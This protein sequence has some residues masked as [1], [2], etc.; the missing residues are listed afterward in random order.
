MRPFF[1]FSR[2]AAN[3]VVPVLLTLL[4]KQDE[5][6]GD[7]EYNIS[8]AAYQCLQLYAQAVGAT[9]IPPVIQF[10]E[11][12]LR[13]ED[14]HNRDAAVSAFGAIMDGPEEKVLE[15]IVKSGMQPLISMM[16]DPSV[17]VRDSTAYALGRITEACSEA[18]D[19]AQ[20]LEPLLRSLFTGLL[21]SPKMGASC[22]WAL[23]NLAERFAGEYGAQQ[24]PITPHF[25]EAVSNLLTVTARPDCET[26]VRTAA[27]E[28]L[29]AFV[30]SAAIESLPAIASLSDVIIKRLEETIPMQTQVVSVEDKITLED[31]QTSLCAVLQA[32]IQRLDK[33]IMPQ[34][35]RIMQ[36]QLQIL[37]TV[38]GKSL[39]P[40]AV[41]ATIGSLA[42]TMEEE[43][44]K[45]MEAFAPFLYNALGNQEEPSLCSMAI[46]L[47]SD[48]TRST[49]ERSQPFCDN[50]MNYLL[51]NL[52]VRPR[53]P[54][55]YDNISAFRCCSLLTL[56][57]RALRFPTSSSLQFSSA[58]EILPAPSLVTSRRTCRLSLGS[59]SK[60]RLSLPHPKA[61][62][63][64]SITSYPYGRV[65]WTLGVA[66][67]VP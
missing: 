57:F 38:G 60:R 31:I 25:N 45:Y 55:S 33:E 17:Q 56:Y 42:N 49:G 67:L 6:A 12:N 32:I 50:F 1:N 44:I 4:T 39:V 51:N 28:V 66:L 37:Q 29:N 21:N 63:R 7:D 59:C 24:N 36:V 16:D 64:C 13:S 30:Q 52:R 53:L 40:E 2:V 14:W 8:R 62:M 15:P 11:A 20:H 3:E 61:P 35:D 19:A 22:C 47:V 43:F 65:S 46:G 9:V 23:M 48:I 58:S 54:S 41:F 26:A 34:G 10:V 18:V 5:D 27:Y